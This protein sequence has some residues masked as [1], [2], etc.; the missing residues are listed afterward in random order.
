M[1]Q[2]GRLSKLVRVSRGG[3]E[4][5]VQSPKLP[6]GVCRSVEEWECE[7][8]DIAGF[9]SPKSDL[10]QFLSLDERLRRTLPS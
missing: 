1:G 4:R 8:Q 2:M 9:A 6:L 3:E 5:P 10:A 7:I